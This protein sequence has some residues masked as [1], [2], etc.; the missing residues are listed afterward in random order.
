MAER[1]LPDGFRKVN[2]YNYPTI[3]CYEENYGERHIILIYFF[4]NGTILSF[5]YLF[6]ICIKHVPFRSRIATNQILVLHH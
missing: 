2:S 3:T 4:A 1:K 6:V 5:N